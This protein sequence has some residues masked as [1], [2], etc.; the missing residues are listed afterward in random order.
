MSR[1]KEG[2]VKFCLAFSCLLLAFS[3]SYIRLFIP[4]EKTIND[5]KQ[6]Y[7]MLC[8]NI[9]DKELDVAYLLFDSSHTNAMTMSDFHKVWYLPFLSHPNKDQTLCYRIENPQCITF[10]ATT[11]YLCGI[12]LHLKAR[13]SVIDNKWRVSEVSEVDMSYGDHSCI[14]HYFVD[15]PKYFFI[16]LFEK[17]RKWL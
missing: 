1:T 2:I 6:S 12:H 16:T 10:I 5:I 11:D 8:N 3:I 14:R 4:D 17:A 15:L 9:E 13:Q 7:N